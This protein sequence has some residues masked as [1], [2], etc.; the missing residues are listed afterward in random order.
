M[1]LRKF[2]D[3][4]L[5]NLEQQVQAHQE[6]YNWINQNTTW[7]N[8]ALSKSTLSVYGRDNIVLAN[9][10]NYVRGKLS[11]V[12]LTGPGILKQSEGRVESFVNTV[13]SSLR[14]AAQSCKMTTFA[15]METSL[16][17]RFRTTVVIIVARK[18]GEDEVS[19]A[20]YKAVYDI[21]ANSNAYWHDRTEHLQRSSGWAIHLAL[22][23]FRVNCDALLMYLSDPNQNAT[24]MKTMTRQQIMD[25][26]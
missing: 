9:V 8:V 5:Y 4:V 6:D 2:K 13:E 15:S 26:F 20:V 21:I 3:E 19:L 25:S 12:E 24:I 7:K 22:E 1:A 10:G 16:G 17:G 14:Y 11:D 18:L 23:D